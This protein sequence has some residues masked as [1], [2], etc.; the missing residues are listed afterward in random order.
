MIIKIINNSIYLSYKI[1]AQ[2][3]CG[4]DSLI[5]VTE[6]CVWIIG[7]LGQL[8]IVQSISNDPLTRNCCVREAAYSF[9]FPQNFFNIDYSAGLVPAQE[10]LHKAEKPV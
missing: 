8:C 2:R 1:S 3:A 4:C 7:Q 5:E 6:I 9:K 10:I